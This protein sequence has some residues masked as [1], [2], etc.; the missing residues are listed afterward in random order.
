MD[1]KE[2][3]GILKEIGG[4]LNKLFDLLQEGSSVEISVYQEKKLITNEPKPL[5]KKLIVFKPKSSISLDVKR[6]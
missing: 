2:V 4:H 6:K 3:Q 5:P 1:Q